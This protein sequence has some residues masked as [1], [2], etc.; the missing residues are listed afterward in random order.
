MVFEELLQGARPVI[1]G[2]GRLSMVQG[3]GGLIATQTPPTVE[4]TDYSGEPERKYTITIRYNQNIEVT[5]EKSYSEILALKNTIQGNPAWEPVC[6]GFSMLLPVPT[7]VERVRL[8]EQIIEGRKENIKN[9][10]ERV[11]GYLFGRQEMERF[12]QLLRGSVRP[13]SRK[14]LEATAEAATTAATTAATSVRSQIEDRFDWIA[15]AAR[16]GAEGGAEG[17]Q[18]GGT[19][20]RKKNKKKRTKKRKTKKRTKKKTKKKTKKRKTKKRTKRN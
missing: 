13:T 15:R 20:K 11:S 3:Q 8:T 16:G 18:I 6:R 9:Y 2:A 1:A 4:I 10:L 17:P 12:I 14:R 5:V 7:W 19:R